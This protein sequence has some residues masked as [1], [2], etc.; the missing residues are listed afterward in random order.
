LKLLGWHTQN[1]HRHLFWQW[2]LLQICAWAGLRQIIRR[3][4]QQ[5]LL[6]Q[7]DCKKP[8]TAQVLEQ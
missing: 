8:F 5:H 6:Q 7:H 3:F 2:L 4:L 1:T